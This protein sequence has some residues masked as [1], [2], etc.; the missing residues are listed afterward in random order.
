MQS[1]SSFRIWKFGF[2]ICSP[3]LYVDT[4]PCANVL[5]VRQKMLTV[6]NLTKTYG[7]QTVFE[8]TSFTLGKGE[9]V[10]LV[11]RN[12][13][14]KTTLF[15]LILGEESADSGIISIPRQYRIAHLSQTIS[16]SKETVV[17]EACRDLKAEEDGSDRT[18]KAKAILLGLGFTEDDFN[19]RPHTLS[20]GYQIRL[21]LARILAS[22]PDLLLL[23]EPTNYLDILS[24]RWLSQFLSRWKSE[25]IL[26]THDRN[27]MDEVTTHT[28]GIHRYGIRKIAGSTHKLYQQILK[29][30]EVY[31]Q[32]RINE[33]KRRKEIE[34]FIA[35]FRAQASRAKAVQSR[36][37]TLKKKGS[38]SKMHEAKNLDF[39]FR[40]APFQGKWPMEVKDLKFSYGP[41]EPLLV[42][43]L[44]LAVGRFDRIGIIGKN[45]KGKTTLLSLLA[46]EL[47][48]TGGT[49]SRHENV[50]M[51]YFGQTNIDRLDPQNTVEEEILNTLPE[52]GRGSARNIC[53]IMMFEGDRALKKIGVLS[54]G[55]RSRVL[56]GKLLVNPANMLLLDEP[57]NHLDMES[58]D[59][60]VEA[61]DAFEGAVLIATHSEMILEA[62]ATKLIV[63]DGGRVEVFQGTY[64]DFLER[65]GWQSEGCATDGTGGK[66]GPAMRGSARRDFRR[67]KAELIASRSQILGPLQKAI[68]SLEGRIIELDE[69]MRENNESL[70]RASR[71]GEGKSIVALS[72]AIHEARKEVEIAFEELEKVS[73][74]FHGKAKEFEA[75][76]SELEASSDEPKP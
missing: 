58:I 20:G 30:E 11:G 62:V 55:E 75:L 6:T 13:S 41:E 39:E 76:M 26:I 61:I 70:L 17:K 65:V 16:F 23:D 49:V 32:T 74:E 5:Y 66:Q 43:G 63:F 51:G 14:G 68:S 54:G 18:Y 47:T 31:E 59:S 72:M 71:A 21:N 46:G 33:E 37:R 50:K 2:R 12:G 3:G 57:T 53:G 56:L 8:E 38:L 44:T 42:D 10:G 60:L 15:R 1:R 29:D 9:R 25:F 27:F 36:I 28:M 40:S 48:P 34:Q 4:P 45:G 64:L 35:R 22:E 52:L 67:M 7:L 24:V 73:V 69:Q 19:R